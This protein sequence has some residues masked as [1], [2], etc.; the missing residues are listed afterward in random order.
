ML[1]VCFHKASWRIFLGI[2]L[3]LLQLLHFDQSTGQEMLA[4]CEKGPHGLAQPSCCPL[5]DSPN[6]ENPVN[7]CDCNSCFCCGATH[8]FALIIPFAL[9]SAPIDIAQAHQALGFCPIKVCP[10]PG[11]PSTWLLPKAGYL[12]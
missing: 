8:L 2:G 9:E 1:A 5:K 10:S 12:S 11:Y 7:G 3:V 6:P 4:C